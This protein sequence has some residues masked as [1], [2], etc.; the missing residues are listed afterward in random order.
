MTNGNQS[1]N[2]FPNEDNG[3]T[4]ELD[5]REINDQDG[6]GVADEFDTDDDNDGIL[7]TLECGSVLSD[8]GFEAITGLTVNSNNLG[9]DISPWI[10]SDP[11]NVIEVDG[12][13]GG[14]YG[15][16]GPEYDARGLAGNYYDINGSGDIYQSLRFRIQQQFPTEGSFLLEM[17]QPVMET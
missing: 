7:D 8:G 15:V 17:D 4:P 2:S 9:E 13:G 11:T 14:S 16:G 3:N 12:N 6:D 10:T 5:W 1:S